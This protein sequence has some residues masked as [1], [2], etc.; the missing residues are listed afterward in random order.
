MAIKESAE[1]AAALNAQVEAAQHI[2]DCA[3]CH[4]LFRAAYEAAY[5]QFSL[6]V[7]DRFPWGITYKLLPELRRCEDW[8]KG[9]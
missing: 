2:R 4:R 5:Q 1:I 6:P 7:S 3:L 8:P 9:V